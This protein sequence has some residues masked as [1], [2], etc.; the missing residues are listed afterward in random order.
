MKSLC[1]VCVCWCVYKNSSIFPSFCDATIGTCLFLTQIH[2]LLCGSTS[3]WGDHKCLVLLQTHWKMKIDGDFMR[4]FSCPDK[5]TVYFSW[6]CK[7]RKLSLDNLALYS[8]N[9]EECPLKLSH[10]RVND[11]NFCQ[12]S[13]S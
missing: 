9:V 5:I 8:P 6:F 4:T 13:I 1:L 3:G 7:S 10:E 12:Y 11:P 2:P